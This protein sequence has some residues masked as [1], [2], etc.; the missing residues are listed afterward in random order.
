V[1]SAQA[2]PK[3]SA[4]LNRKHGILLWAGRRIGMFVAFVFVFVGVVWAAMELEV[5]SRPFEGNAIYYIDWK[6]LRFSGQS[7]VFFY[8]GCGMVA[9]GL[10][11]LCFQR[12]RD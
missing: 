5:V 12:T 11:Y 4:K 7:P 10:T 1:A 9:A 6:S 2:E 8:M 3:T